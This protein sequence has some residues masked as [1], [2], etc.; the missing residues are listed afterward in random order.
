MSIISDTLNFVCT[1]CKG[2]V[3]VVAIAFAIAPIMKKI[4]AVNPTPLIFNLVFTTHRGVV[5]RTLIIPSANIALIICKEKSNLT[6]RNI[7]F[8][9]EKPYQ[10]LTR[11]ASHCQPF[12]S[13]CFSVLL[14]R[15]MCRN[16]QSYSHIDFAEQGRYLCIGYI[17]KR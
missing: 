3:I 10:Q 4:H 17:L 6:T 8:V 1:S 16:K 14:S 12:D 9:D 5:V 11:E 2:Y 13:F 15:G 7:D